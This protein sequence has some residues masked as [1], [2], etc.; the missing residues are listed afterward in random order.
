MTKKNNVQERKINLWTLALFVLV[1][2]IIALTFMS[3]F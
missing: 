1:G 2:G 3:R